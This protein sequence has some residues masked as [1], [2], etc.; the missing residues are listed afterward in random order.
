MER[1]SGTV[2]FAEMDAA[3]SPDQL[4]TGLVAD[5][6]SVEM[7][8]GTVVL[9][10]T[11][12]AVAHL[13][14][15]G[16]LNESRDFL[17]VGV[18]TITEAVQEAYQRGWVRRQWTQEELTFLR[19]VRSRLMFCSSGEADDELDLYEHD[20]VTWLV[21]DRFAA[22]GRAS[23]EA[24]ATGRTADLNLFVALL[25]EEAIEAGWVEVGGIETY[26]ADERNVYASIGFP[27]WDKR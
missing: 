2:M 21:K 27:R 18:H 22:A 1:W 5:R 19:D 20:R 24:A 3:R 25:L 12:D 26:R 15:R 6:E 23:E 17:D 4:V 8:G 7:T 11:A 14:E 16:I 13:Q 10:F 9:E